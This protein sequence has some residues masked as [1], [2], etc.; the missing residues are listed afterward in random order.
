MRWQMVIPLAL[1]PQAWLDTPLRIRRGLRLP[2]TT[3]PVM[4]SQGANAMAMMTTAQPANTSEVSGR[5]RIIRIA[6]G[7]E[8]GTPRMRVYLA[9][10]PDT[11]YQVDAG[12]IPGLVELILHAMSSES[13]V[14]V[15]FDK[16][17]RRVMRVD[18]V[19]TARPT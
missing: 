2:C 16:R 11:P 12:A 10:Q 3:P 13:L 19:T 4:S 5:S 18:V 9:E 6:A 1:A 8:D 14:E 17:S 7:D 15:V